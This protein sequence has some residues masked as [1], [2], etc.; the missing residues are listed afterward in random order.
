MCAAVSAS[1]GQRPRS[2]GEVS[3]S[4]CVVVAPMWIDAVLLADVTEVRQAGDVHH[5]L[6]RGEAKLHQRHQAHAAR[7]HLRIAARD[8]L[9]SL[10]QI[11][12]RDVLE[13][14]RNHA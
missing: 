12:G 3:I 4:K 1:R 13:F 10:A 14:L 7:Q 6:G 5:A 9:Q 8:Q 11:C 2:S